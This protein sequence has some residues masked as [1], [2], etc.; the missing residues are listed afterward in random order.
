A[1]GGTAIKVA[2]SCANPCLWVG[3]RSVESALGAKVFRAAE[4]LP[5]REGG[6]LRLLRG[7]LDQVALRKRCVHLVRTY[8]ARGPA[9]P[10]VAVLRQH[11]DPPHRDGGPHLGAD[12]R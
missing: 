5:R 10:A 8:R 3:E 6:V 7:H 1:N 12:R 2:R 11:R 4:A 9:Y